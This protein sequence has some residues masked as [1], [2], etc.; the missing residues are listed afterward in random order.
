MS[1]Q[2]IFHIIFNNFGLHQD[3]V[4]REERGWEIKI[5]PDELFNNTAYSCFTKDI[6]S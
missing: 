1:Y 5:I 3:I 2:Q 4:A 6:F